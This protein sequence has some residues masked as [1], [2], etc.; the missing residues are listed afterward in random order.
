MEHN[1]TSIRKRA[2]K[3]LKMVVPCT[4]LFAFVLMALASSS[5]SG[6]VSSDEYRKSFD[7]G[8]EVGEKIGRALGSDATKEIERFEQDTIPMENS[9]MASRD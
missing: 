1:K 2:K 9:Y 8:W 5:N 4:G 6:S 3:I 7:A